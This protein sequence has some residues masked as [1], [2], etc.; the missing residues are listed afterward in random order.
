MSGS[1]RKR[2]LKRMGSK[3]GQRA[4]KTNSYPLRRVVNHHAQE[5]VEIPE[6][7]VGPFKQSFT[8]EAVE[9]ECGHL[10]SPPTHLMGRRYPARMRCWKCAKAAPS[11][12]RE[13]GS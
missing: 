5:T 3:G 4:K 11:E 2:H 6:G 9:L 1:Q 12:S 10:L 13:E 8:R 7:G